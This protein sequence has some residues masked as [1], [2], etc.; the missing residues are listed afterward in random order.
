[1][2]RV[3]LFA[4]IAAMSVALAGCGEDV[5]GPTTGTEPVKFVP[6][7]LEV[8]ADGDF[9]VGNTIQLRA[10]GIDGDERRE[11]LEGVVFASSNEAVG[12]VDENG[13]ARILAGGQ[14]SFSASF[15]E[16]AAEVSSRATCDYPRFSPEFVL[17]RVMPKLSWP[18][19]DRE[20]NAFEFDLEKVFCDAD[21]KDVHT[22]TFVLSA[23][24]CQPCTMYARDLAKQYEELEDLGMRI[25]TIE[26][27]DTTGNPGTTEFARRHL[28]SITGGNVPSIALGDADTQPQ[29]RFVAGSSLL[30]YFPTVFVMRTR[31]MRIIAD[32][33]RWATYLPLARI[34]ADPEADWSRS[35]GNTFRSRCGVGDEESTENM[36]P[37]EALAIEPGTHQ[38]GICMDAPDFYSID[39]QGAW[40]LE[41]GFKHSVGD[42]D[43]YVWDAE[44]DQPL[45]VDGQI[46]ASTGKTDLETIE[47]SGPAVVAIRGFQHAS[48]PYTLTLTEH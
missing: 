39:V 30:E 35:G 40:T 38:G 15:G 22:I 47:F 26:V 25:A 17:G 33:K 36:I 23:G 44:R 34:A 46:V 31:D 8:R 29:S 41:L 11:I 16:L 45:M 7:A 12:T 5:A 18:A 13:R 2:T 21:W 14:V 42:L 1:M 20:G 24:W 28:E 6:T 32:G 37:S 27:E 9:K 48:A 10:I 19:Y 43:V 4:A 3:G